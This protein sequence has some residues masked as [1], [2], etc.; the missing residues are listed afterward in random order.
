MADNLN[1]AKLQEMRDKNGDRINM[2]S[3]DEVKTLFDVL[4]IMEM[5]K[6]D[7][8]Y[9]KALLDER[10]GHLVILEGEKKKERIKPELPKHIPNDD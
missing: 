5:P 2:L 3:Q 10:F 4:G 9:L 7:I 6:S 1:P 8:P